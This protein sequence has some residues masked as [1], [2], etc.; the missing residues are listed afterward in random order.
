MVFENIVSNPVVASAAALVGRNVYGWVVNSLKDGNIQSYEW[1]QLLQT[2]VK[3]GGLSVFAYFGVNAV[4][5]GVSPVDTTA[6]V[7]L[8]DALKS[9]LKKK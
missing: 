1:Q 9:Y 7:A 6:V 3:L 2:L 4:I 8:V 5:E